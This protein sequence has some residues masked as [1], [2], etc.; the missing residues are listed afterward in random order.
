M[1][2]EDKEMDVETSETNNAGTSMKFDLQSTGS[3]VSSTVL[4][5]STIDDKQEGTSGT[6]NNSGK[7]TE[8]SGQKSSMND[9]SPSATIIRPPKSEPQF[10]NDTSSAINRN[11]ES[12]IPTVSQTDSLEIEIKQEDVCASPNTPLPPH[13]ISKIQVCI[14]IICENC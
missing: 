10:R 2:A 8:K 11:L 13:A 5:G 1:F 4:D 3:N 14:I 7:A 9:E 6:G 12:D